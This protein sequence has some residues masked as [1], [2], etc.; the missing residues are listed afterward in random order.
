A[1]RVAVRAGTGGTGSTRVRDGVTASTP[2]T[3]SECDAYALEPAPVAERG[4]LVH[5]AL[6]PT[7]GTRWCA[8][9]F[10]G[11]LLELQTLVCPPRSLCPMYQRLRTLG[12]FS[13]AVR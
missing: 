9:T 12:T 11:K 8:G 7:P 10:T 13:F 6:R 5:V 3:A 4:R 1:V 2:A